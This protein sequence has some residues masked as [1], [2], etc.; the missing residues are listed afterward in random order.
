M[1]LDHNLH[2]FEATCDAKGCPQRWTEDWMVPLTTNNG[3]GTLRFCAH[4]ANR[5]RDAYHA[6]VDS[7][8]LTEVA[9]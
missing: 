2:T 3:M 4:H 1:D 5:Y 9:A 7:T 8:L 6:Y